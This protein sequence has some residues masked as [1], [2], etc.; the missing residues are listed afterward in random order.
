MLSHGD[1][2]RVEL[3]ARSHGEAARRIGA[4]PAG[5]PGVLAASGPGA[6][7]RCRSVAARTGVELG[8]EFLAIPTAKAP[9]C[10]VE[11]AS[12][13]VGAFVRS[14]LVAPQDTRL[15]PIVDAGLAVLRRMSS[16]RLL[17]ILVPGRIMVGVRT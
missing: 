16:L 3:G 4:L 12:A 14:V 9:G 8:R 7:R 6:G 13:P 11:N 2:V 1:A 17:R 5:T 10:L 15:G